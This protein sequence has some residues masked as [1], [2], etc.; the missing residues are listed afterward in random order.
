MEGDGTESE[1]TK[2]ATFV[3]PQRAAQL[4]GDRGANLSKRGMRAK[5]LPM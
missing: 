4:Q 3:P 2:A 5:G 1:D